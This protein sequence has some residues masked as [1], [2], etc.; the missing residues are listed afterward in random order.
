MP[1]LSAHCSPILRRLG[2]MICACFASPATAKDPDAAKFPATLKVSGKPLK[3][4]GNGIRE[5]YFLKVYAIGT[6]S[7]SGSC[8]PQTIISAE[9]TKLIRLEFLRD[10]SAEKFTASLSEAFDRALPAGDNELKAQVA[11]F[12]GWFK[13]EGKE[14]ATYEFTYKAGKGTM[15]NHND[16]TLGQIPGKKFSDLLWGI[17]Y[18]DKTCCEDLRDELIKSCKS[19]T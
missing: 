9:E 12:M 17:Y 7:E 1:S 19:E 18:G 15:L 11:Q 5:K 4:V 3:R 14:G 10:L 6:Y 13:S 2:L 16:K 8:D